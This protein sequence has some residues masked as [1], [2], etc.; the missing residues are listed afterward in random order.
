MSVP[1][2]SKSLREQILE[3]FR[4]CEVC[5]KRVAIAQPLPAIL[6]QATEAGVG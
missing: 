3:F 6:R 5:M 1:V 2:V 4:H